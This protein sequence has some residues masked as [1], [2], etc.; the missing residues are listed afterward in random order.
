[1][2]K[3]V[4]TLGLIVLLIASMFSLAGCIKDS[5]ESIAKKNLE[6]LISAMESEDRDAVKTL[7]ASNKIAGI[8]DFDQSIDELLAYYE[9]DYVSHLGGGPGTSNEKVLAAYPAS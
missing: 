4:L 5:D 2:K 3:I 7:F 8:E 6:K 1:M 9:G